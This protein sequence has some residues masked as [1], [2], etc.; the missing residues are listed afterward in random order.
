MKNFQDLLNAEFHNVEQGEQLIADLTYYLSHA[1]YDH[2]YWSHIAV[3]P[4]VEE[5]KQLWSKREQVKKDVQKTKDFWEQV[6]VPGN[7]KLMAHLQ[8]EIERLQEDLGDCAGCGETFCPTDEQAE[9]AET[10]RCGE[11]LEVEHTVMH[12]D[13]ALKAVDENRNLSLA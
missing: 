1:E 12:V 2:P 10:I 7:L 6:V 3:P 5:M 4:S 13:C 8:D 11:Y 9:L